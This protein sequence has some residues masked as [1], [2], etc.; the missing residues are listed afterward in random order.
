MRPV[1]DGADP[2]DERR[3][4]TE[5]RA[6]AWFSWTV[7]VAGL[8]VLMFAV[9]PRLGWI[10]SGVVFL[11]WYAVDV[12]LDRLLWPRVSRRVASWWLARPTTRARP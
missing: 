12:V 9:F 1:H 11:L 10:W 5:A 3:R 7:W 2:V 8:A 4:R 6:A